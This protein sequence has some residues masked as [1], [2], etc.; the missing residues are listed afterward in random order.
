MKKDYMVFTRYVA[1]QL[2]QKGFKILRLKPD[3]VDKTHTIYIF[4]W[5]DDIE[6]VVSEIN[7]K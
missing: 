7:K 4:E 3:K 5:S 1:N 6:R 2:I